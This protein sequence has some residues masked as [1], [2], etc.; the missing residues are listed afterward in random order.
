M[1]IA[2]GPIKQDS[3]R[4]FH[5]FGIKLEEIKHWEHYGYIWGQNS[6]GFS[7]SFKKKIIP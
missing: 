2:F 3:S 7:P 5:P 1:R 6:D 4:S